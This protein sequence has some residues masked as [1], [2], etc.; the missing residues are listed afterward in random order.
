MPFK[1]TGKDTYK[2][3][4][5]KKFTSQT[6][7]SKIRRICD[8]KTEDWF[9]LDDNYNVWTC[10]CKMD[11]NMRVSLCLSICEHLEAEGELRELKRKIAQ[12]RKRLGILEK[13]TS[14]EL[15]ILLER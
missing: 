6:P 9:H 3:Q 1:K 8:Q 2:S 12:E 15:D 7:P 14:E 10:D 5:G 4:S 13:T 11:A